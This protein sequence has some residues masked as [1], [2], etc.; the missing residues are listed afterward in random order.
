[1]HRI[2]PLFLLLISLVF[3]APAQAFTAY[4]TH[5]GPARGHAEDGV[6]I[7]QIT[8]E[9][10]LGD[11]IYYALADKDGNLVALTPAVSANMHELD[12]KREKKCAV[13][14]LWYFSFARMGI[15]DM[16]DS[17]AQQERKP[18]IGRGNDAEKQAWIAFINGGKGGRFETFR[19]NDLLRKPF[20]VTNVYGK[21]AKANDVFIAHLA[22][23]LLSL[24]IVLVF[25]VS[26]RA[27]KKDKIGYLII[28]L[29]GYGLAVI[30]ALVLFISAFAVPLPY[31]AATIFFM[32]FC[33]RGAYRLAVNS[34]GR[35][36]EP[37]NG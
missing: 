9:G 27:I 36:S 11:H 34:Q 20:G 24:F 31:Y 23:C 22:T 21:E 3:A 26:T 6:Q 1:M 25:Y 18:L 8:A 15:W 10:F 16:S 14:D 33:L 32:L 7:I 29:I 30:A 2:L 37:L 4:A 35:K 28:G 12:C 5:M 19:F 17:A 13:Y